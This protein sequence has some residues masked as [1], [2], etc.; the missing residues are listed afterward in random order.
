MKKKSTYFFN[1]AK[2]FSFLAL[3]L[4]TGLMLTQFVWLSPSEHRTESTHFTEKANL[5]LRRTAHNLL[6][7]SGDSTSQ[8]PPVQVINNH[9]FLIRLEQP[10]DYDAL[11]ELL[12]ASLKLQQ[13]KQN[14]NVA[15][16]DCKKGQLHLGYSSLD[17]LKNDIAC[18]GREQAQNCSNIQVTF[19]DSSKSPVLPS[20]MY[21]V[22]YVF[23]LGGYVVWHRKSKINQP[24]PTEVQDPTAETTDI[25]TIGQTSFSFLHRRL[26]V[27]EVSHALTYREAKLLNLFY[28]RPNQILERDFILESVWQDEGI[29]V[30]RSLDVF[31]SRLRKML[32]KDQTVRI[33]TIHGVGYQLEALTGNSPAA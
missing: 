18:V 17:L 31:V 13:I 32:Q 6:K 25:L 30:G 15:V 11:P 16:L 5:A 9:T 28:Q 14:Y 26:T 29:F 22:G 12:Q 20:W 10:F 8:I 21:A 2:P 23:I 3:L 24:M 19:V 4:L 1:K 7:A 27:V 33:A